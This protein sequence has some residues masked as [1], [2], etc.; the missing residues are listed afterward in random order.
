MNRT[1]RNLVA[2]HFKSARFRLEVTTGQMLEVN[3]TERSPEDYVVELLAHTDL[4]LALDRL[5][6]RMRRATLLW[7]TGASTAEIAQRL[8]ITRGTVR[9]HLH[10]A[11][12][13]LAADPALAR[14]IMAVTGC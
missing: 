13:R 2:D 14:T 12:R 4:A 5:P 10:Q 7:A 8:G 6:H 9:V 11:R 1:A 3:E